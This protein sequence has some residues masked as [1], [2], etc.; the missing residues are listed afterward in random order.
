M[1]HKDGYTGD[2]FYV[3]MD[4]HYVGDDG[5]VVPRNFPEFF[6]RMPEFVHNWVKKH[7]YRYASQED[8]EDMSQDLLIHLSNLPTVSKYR[9]MGKTD[10]VET[11]DPFQQYGASERRFRSY[12]NF[13]LSNKLNTMHG[14]QK[15]NPLSHPNNMTVTACVDTEHEMMRLDAT[16]EYLYQNSASFCAK[17][18]RSGVIMDESVLTTEFTEFVWRENTVAATALDAARQAGS[19]ADARRQWCV[20]CGRM[21]SMVEID[22]GNHY[23]HEIGMSQKE[24][25]RARG[26][27]RELARKFLQIGR[28]S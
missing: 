17:T 19:F 14:K 12:I 1:A 13:C 28:Y 21:A 5:F 8:I 22:S 23:G 2:K 9:D 7:F 10:V 15:R 24:F 20:T 6:G 11:F 18:E 26:K 3:L 27:I 25:N 16:D 4:G